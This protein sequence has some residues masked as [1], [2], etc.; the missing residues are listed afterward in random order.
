MSEFL[1]QLAG[2]DSVTF[3]GAI[4]VI[5]ILLFKITGY[6]GK[7]IP[8]DKTGVLGVIRKICNFIN[9]YTPNVTTSK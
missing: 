7:K 5:V 6:I 4:A 1:L 2:G 9:L 3:N 8:D